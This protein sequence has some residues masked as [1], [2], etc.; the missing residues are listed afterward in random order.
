MSDILS[1]CKIKYSAVSK[2]DPELF[3]MLVR[4]TEYE[5]ST[6]KMIPSENFVDDDV[7]QLNGSIL[8]NK[9]SEGYPNA[10]YYEGNEIIDEIEN[11]AI[12]RAKSVFG[13]EHANVQAYSGAPA[14]Q[15]V[16]R[17][18]LQ[19][20]EKLMGMPVPQGGHLTHGWKVNFSGIDY[21][22]VHYGLNAA[23]GLIDLKE[24]REIAL[25]ERPRVIIVGAT[26]YPR[27]LDYAGFAAI[28][29]EVGAYLVADIA[30]ISGL[31]AAGCH[32]SPLPYCDV[33]TTTTHKILRG[34]RAAII[35]SRIQ[36]R[37]NPDAKQSLAQR[38]D[39]AVFPRLQAGPH[40]HTIAA[41]AVTLKHA[42][43]EE[44]K[45][46]AK[47]VVANAKALSEALLALGYKLVTGGTDNHLFIIDF[48]DT[49]NT[50]KDTAKAL[51]RAGI[52]AN[53]NTVP[54]DPRPPAITSGVRMGTPALTSMGMK[55]EHMKTIAGFIHRVCSNIQDEEVIAAVR[56]EVKELCSNF[57]IPG[58][59]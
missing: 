6:L 52:I 10:R 58:I 37:V 31:I 41:I 44:Y 24:V 18:L 36:D 48:R 12:N 19:P 59:N 45:T 56:A 55:E 43:S 1:S 26:A 8:T 57:R 27:T 35:L 38:I 42:A 30:H 34:P 33:I 15:A 13:A 3:D 16:F 49:K 20:G 47:Q 28:A 53:F 9:Y 39:R 2:S 25:R 29:Q 17:A 51:A 14:N 5:A 50:G 40:M 46:Y 23:T 21:V 11:L 32:P 54:G 4:Q 22:P 7:L